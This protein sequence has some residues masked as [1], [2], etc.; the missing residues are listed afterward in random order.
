M[1]R[2]NAPTGSVMTP[3]TPFIP[4]A[5]LSE[6]LYREAVAPIL[7]RRY[8]SL[9]HSAA[10]IGYGSDVLGYDTVR[11]MDHEWGPR[12][13]LF[14]PDAEASRLAPEIHEHLRHK[15]PKHVLGF[16]THFGSTVETG[17]R[18]M[19]R[20]DDGP[21]EH[22]VE[23]LSL[24]AFLRDRFGLDGYRDLTPVDWLTLTDQALLE[25]TAG[26]VF[27]DGLGEL[28]P[29]R[30]ALAYYPDQIWRYRL[31]AEWAR[32]GELEAF[33]GRTAEVGDEIGSALVTASLTRDVMRLAFLMERRYAPSPKWFGTAFVRLP[34]GPELAR[35]LDAALAA[36]S[37]PDREQGLTA[38]YR[39]I[40]SMLN[41][42]EI[43]SPRSVEPTPFFGRPFLVI[44]GGEFATAIRETITDRDVLALPRDVG[45]IDQFVD[46]TA[47]LC[48]YRARLSTFY[49]TT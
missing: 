12:L 14:I 2:G 13:L 49:R 16:S 18:T 32:I 27:H 48:H 19:Q 43:T 4:G 22:K 41:T 25:L 39:I 44:H 30:A 31:A 45:G 6:V 36:R 47:V 28:Q 11:S 21:V 8:P 1:L 15:L 33:V 26:A 10:L 29:M 46:S 23:I 3:E 40:A 35:H 38:A 20:T 37:W 7:A 34:C 42:L 17:T 9:P 5:R 24:I